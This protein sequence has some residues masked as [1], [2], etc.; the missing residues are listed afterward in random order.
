MAL[1]ESTRRAQTASA[2]SFDRIPE[3]GLVCWGVAGSW[4]VLSN[5][6]VNER[7]RALLTFTLQT[8]VGGQG[9][10]GGGLLE[11]KVARPDGPGQK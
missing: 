10:A 6:A 3:S 11:R 2:R 9:A 4:E 8:C 7:A 1:E 5:E